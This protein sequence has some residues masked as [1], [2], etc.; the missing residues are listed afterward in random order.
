MNRFALFLAFLGAS[1]TLSEATYFLPLAAGK[2][3]LRGF[4]GAYVAKLAI[5]GAVMQGLHV[6]YRRGR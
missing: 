1:L 5:I 2:E 3:A 4:I 6:G